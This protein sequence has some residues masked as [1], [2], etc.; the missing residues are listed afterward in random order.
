MSI[1]KLSACIM[2]ATTSPFT[3]ATD[4]CN[5]PEVSPEQAAIIA[6]KSFAK[7][8]GVENKDNLFLMSLSF[9]YI[10]CEWSAMYSRE[11]NYFPEHPMSY[12]FVF[13]NGSN[14][15]LLKF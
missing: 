3:I 8:D 5:G 2:L 12:T 1:L 13:V 10:D 15:K 14:V 7:Y 9:D 6:G 11:A 4:L